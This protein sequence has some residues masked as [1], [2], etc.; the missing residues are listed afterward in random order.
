[1]IV[2]IPHAKV[3]YRQAIFSQRTPASKEV[4]GFLWA[5]VVLNLPVTFAPL[6]T[7]TAVRKA[8]RHTQSR[9]VN[10]R[11]VTLTYRDRTDPCHLRCIL[12]R[13]SCIRRSPVMATNASAN[14][15][16]VGGS[17]IAAARG[18]A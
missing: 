1:M 15:S 6:A 17:G 3:G 2:C 13:M 12:D 9:C 5:A 16:A 7:W 10:D 18:S 11:V 4:R 14:N 8:I